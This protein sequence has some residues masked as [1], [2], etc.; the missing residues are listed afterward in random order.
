MLLATLL[1]SLNTD[2]L[3]ALLLTLIAQEVAS[4]PPA[5]SSDKLD[6]GQERL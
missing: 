1:V 5:K 3:M 2:A 6:V 4:L